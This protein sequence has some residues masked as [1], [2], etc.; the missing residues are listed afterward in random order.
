[1]A[2]QPTWS[3]IFD[4]DRKT[5]ALKLGRNRLDDYATKYLSRRC[6]EA[7]ST[8]MPLPVDKILADEGLVVK[9][10]SL[11]KNLDVFGCCVLL[12]GEVPIYEAHRLAP[13]ILMPAKSFRKKAEELN[14]EIRAK[15]TDDSPSCDGLIEALSKFFIVSRSSVK[16][17]LLEVGL[18]EE[19]VKFDDYEDVYAEV[20]SRD[21]FVPITPSEAFELLHTNTALQKWIQKDCFIF[22][23]GY[24]VLA[25]P[26]YV[27]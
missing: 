26:K 24:F 6:K 8:P 21:E 5:G 1:M 19:L 23:E 13:R 20:N 22:A 25:G 4:T 14:S 16:Y 3:D 18:M 9:E 11:S 27:K 10:V 12:D 15:K 17:R 7:L 2:T